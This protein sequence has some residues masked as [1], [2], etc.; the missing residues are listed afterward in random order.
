MEVKPESKPVTPKKVSTSVRSSPRKSSPCKL[1][2]RKQSPRKAAIKTEKNGKES[3]SDSSD[4]DSDSENVEA[5]RLRN[6]EDNHRFLAELGIQ[7]TKEKIFESSPAAAAKR[8]DVKGLKRGSVETTP[9]STPPRR[10]SLRQRKV[11]SDGLQLAPDY[12]EPSVAEIRLGLVRKPRIVSGVSGAKV[13]VSGSTGAAT[14][15]DKSGRKPTTPTPLNVFLSN[16]PM[17][18][19]D[20]DDLTIEMGNGPDAEEEF[21]KE[22]EARR[23]AREKQRAKKCKGFISGVV[24]VVIDA[25]EVGRD[26]VKGKSEASFLADLKKL[27]CGQTLE[28][29]VRCFGFCFVCI[30]SYYTS[31]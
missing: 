5:L 19:V 14:S 24:D 28:R 8:R 15:D 2:P 22:L 7:R 20:E 16:P 25:P 23:E 18:E 29:K 6:I 1:S 12:R 10:V 9:K 31:R 26:G 11:D 30:I 27:K 21:K 3:G 4:S 13:D 17:D